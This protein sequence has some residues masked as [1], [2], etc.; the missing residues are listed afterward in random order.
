MKLL[1]NGTEI[2]KSEYTDGNGLTI[3]TVEVTVGGSK[4]KTVSQEFV[5]FGSAYDLVNTNIIQ[6]PNGLNAFLS[7]KIYEDKC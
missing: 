6:N 5:L 7:V 3:T 1:I 2:D 4:E